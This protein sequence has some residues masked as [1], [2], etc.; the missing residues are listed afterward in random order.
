M[1]E[2]IQLTSC[3]ATPNHQPKQLLDLAYLE[4][5]LISALTVGPVLDRLVSETDYCVFAF[6]NAS[7][8]LAPP[9]VS[10]C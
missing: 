4:I 5:V 3:D 9:K 1:K 6:C 10:F 2:S 7:H 8:F